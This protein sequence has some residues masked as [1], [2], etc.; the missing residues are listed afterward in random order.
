MQTRQCNS[1]LI[2][3]TTKQCCDERCSGETACSRGCETTPPRSLTF[4]CR[5]SQAAAVLSASYRLGRHGPWQPRLGPEGGQQ[6]CWER[7]TGEGDSQH[8]LGEI[9]L[10][11]PTQKDIFELRCP[12]HLSSPNCECPH[13]LLRQNTCQTIN[14][15]PHANLHGSPTTP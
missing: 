10:V 3:Q 5:L 2:P 6:I 12:T 13:N 14:T 4:A 15:V 7:E 11:M 8:C 1:T 9:F